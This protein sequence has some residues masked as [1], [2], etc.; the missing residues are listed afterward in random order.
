V[1][2]LLPGNFISAQN[3]DFTTAGVGAYGKQNGNVNI[4]AG[5]DVTGDYLVANG[6]GKIFA[7]VEMDAAGN[8]ITDVSGNYVLGNSGSA[9]NNQLNPNL[10]L[11][12]S[13]VVGT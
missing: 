10:A 11:N 12:S 6:T 1:T 4:V 5:G 9:G 3:N 13:A 7:G 8:P 2:S